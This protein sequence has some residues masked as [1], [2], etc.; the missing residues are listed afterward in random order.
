MDEW[1]EAIVQALKPLGASLSLESLD[2]FLEPRTMVQFV[3][4]LA[5]RV[6]SAAAREVFVIL[7]V[8]FGL[9]EVPKMAA[10]L[11]GILE[12]GGGLPPRFS[13]LCHRYQPLS[14]R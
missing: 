12:G 10:R 8:V 13:G 4:L 9:M 1:T 2:S 3:A 6:G 5:Q 14:L 7:L 11:P